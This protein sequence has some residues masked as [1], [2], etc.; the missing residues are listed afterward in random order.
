[1]LLYF[2]TAAQ[3]NVAPNGLTL[4]FV[5]TESTG[6]VNEV[7]SNV[8]RV[9]NNSGRTYVFNLEL[10]SPQGWQSMLDRDKV[11]NVR[12]GDTLYIPTRIIPQKS[13]TGNVNYFINATAVTTDGIPVA[14]APWSM[15]IKKVS[16]WFAS[17]VNS[18]A[19]FPSGGNETEFKINVRNQGNSSENVIILFNPDVKIKVLDQQGNPFAEDALQLALPVDIDTVLTFKVQLDDKVKKES[20]FSAGDI[21]EEQEDNSNYKV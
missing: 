19:Y 5:K 14:S 6:S 16:R 20:F 9:V 17:M 8:L 7:A 2:T 4:Q 11:Y 10:S 18:E 1:M 15:Q 12:N 21:T 3:Q 13:S